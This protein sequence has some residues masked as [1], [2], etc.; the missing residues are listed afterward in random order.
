[1]ICLPSW[2]NNRLFLA[3]ILLP[4]CDIA[5]MAS[6]QTKVGQNEIWDGANILPTE[7]ISGLGGYVYA[8]EEPSPPGNDGVSNIMSPS[9]LWLVSAVA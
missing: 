1:V 3:L 6:T 4:T 9:L 7:R 5:V 8:F 2:T